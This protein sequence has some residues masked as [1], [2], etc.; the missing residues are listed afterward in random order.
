MKMYTLAV[1]QKKFLK[2]FFFNSDICRI[3]AL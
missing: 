3:I 2:D 1:A